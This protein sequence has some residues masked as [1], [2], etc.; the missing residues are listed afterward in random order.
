MLWT[1]AFLHDLVREK[2]GDAR[3]VVVSNREPYSHVFS[4]AEVQC[5]RPT[6]MVTACLC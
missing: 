4:G 1:D 2:L 3:L 6:R 5:E